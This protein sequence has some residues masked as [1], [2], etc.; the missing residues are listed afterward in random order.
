M[1][2]QQRDKQNDQCECKP[3]NQSHTSERRMCREV[4]PGQDGRRLGG[5]AVGLRGVGQADNQV[6]RVCSNGRFV[7][8]TLW[9]DH[10]SASL[11]DD[12]NF[13]DLEP[14]QYLVASLCPSCR[15][16]W[17]AEISVEV[18]PASLK[19]DR[20]KSRVRRFPSNWV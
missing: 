2:E 19:G 7:C 18:F 20:P 15:S 3:S 11:E 17:L 6:R 10:G 12:R 8:L 9:R 13:L 14:V 16:G 4:P 5:S 1:G